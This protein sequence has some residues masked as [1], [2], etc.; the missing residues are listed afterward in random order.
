MQPIYQYIVWE[1]GPLK[2]QKAFF[3]LFLEHVCFL[4]DFEGW[5]ETW[6]QQHYFLLY[7]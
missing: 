4:V 2:I 6:T 5:F 7:N 3:F 1:S